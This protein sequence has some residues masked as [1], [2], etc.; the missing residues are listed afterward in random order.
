MGDVFA[1]EVEWAK[2]FEEVANNSIIMQFPKP[3]E[4]LTWHLKPLYIKAL[5][6][7]KPINQ[8]FIDGG[9]ILNVMLVITLKKLGKNKSNLISTNMKMKNFT[10]DVMA[11]IRVLAVDITMRPKAFN[12]I[13]FVVDAKLSYSILLSRDWIHFYQSVLATLH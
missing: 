4:D 7:G 6:N 12:F 3:L 13:I 10:G 5:I 8:V 9:A 2:L 1:E 11:T